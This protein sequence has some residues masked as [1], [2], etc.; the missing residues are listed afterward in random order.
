MRYVF[1]TG[2][3]RGLGNALLEMFQEDRIIS[4][5]RSKVETEYPLYKE[6][7]VDFLDEKELESTVDEIFGSIEP[8]PGDEVFLINNAGVVDPVKSVENIDAEGFLN[9]YKVNVLAPALFMK[10]FVNQFKDLRGAKRILTVSSG[11]AL[12]PTE[13]WAAYCSSKA[14]VNM[15]SDVLRLEMDR[16]QYP[17]FTATFR[18]G[19]IDT[20]MQSEI[21]SSEENEFPDVE[22]F[23]KFKETNKLYNKKTVAYV[24]KRVITSDNFAFS[25]S[26]SIS[27]FL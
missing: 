12:N 6:F 25:E 13:G 19:V 2:T 14:A 4:I 18:P 9:N 23:K 1:I 15:V 8:E 10:G 27:D 22:R 7:Y 16:L 11:A 26:F 3:S 20:D 24:L 5:S 21:R 17:I